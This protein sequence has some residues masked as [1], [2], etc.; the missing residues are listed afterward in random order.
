MA[1]ARDE[2][3][4]VSRGPLLRGRTVRPLAAATL[5]AA[6]VLLAVGG[7]ARA[8]TDP[9]DGGFCV[10]HVGV[11]GTTAVVG[12]VSDHKVGATAVS[13]SYTPAKAGRYTVNTASRWQI[14]RYSCDAANTCKFDVVAQGGGISTDA[15]VTQ[16][17]FLPPPGMTTKTVWVQI[18]NSVCGGAPLYPC[19]TA[20]Q[21]TVGDDPSAP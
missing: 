17:T 5:L 19:G 6:G 15:A 20:G 9:S 21:I 11:A 1:P 4:P 2:M 16:G 13:C 18:W 7:L 3:S 14:Y 8:D 10:D 12:A